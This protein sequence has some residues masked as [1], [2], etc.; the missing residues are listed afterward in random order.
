[1]ILTK[2]V[3]TVAGVAFTGGFLLIFSV[4]ERVNRGKSSAARP[5]THV[6]Q[7]N[8]QTSETVSTETLGLKKPYTKVVAI[9]SP[10]N[11]F[12]LEKALAETDPDTTSVVVMTAKLLPEGDATVRSDLDPYDQALMTA[13][14]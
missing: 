7:F 13:V 12:M 10:Y 9:R 11:L 8:V 14:V 5:H 2:E 6:E 4:S 3:A 1:N